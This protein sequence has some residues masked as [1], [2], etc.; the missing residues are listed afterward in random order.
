[1]NQENQN[2]A[3]NIPQPAQQPRSELPPLEPKQP[4]TQ[5]KAPQL[6]KEEIEKKKLAFQK[7]IKI[8]GFAVIGFTAII[9]IFSMAKIIY[10]QNKETYS[11]SQ[12]QES[13][14]SSG[15]SVPSNNQH[16]LPDDSWEIYSSEK[17][18]L[19]FEYPKGDLLKISDVSENEIA[20]QVLSKDIVPQENPT[21]DNLVKGYIFQV[22]PLKLEARDLE[23]AVS[24]KRDFYQ[25]QCAE[26]SSVTDIIGVE[27]SGIE[28]RGFMIYNCNSDYDISYVAANGYIYEVIQIFKGDVGF[29]QVYKAKANQI[30]SL[31]KIEQET[32]AESPFVEF[33]SKYG[34]SFSYPRGLDSQYSN[35]PF[36][37]K[38][39][40]ERVITIAEN[41][42]TN[43]VGFYYDRSPK[44]DFDTY[45]N[46]QIQILIDD[47]V[48]VKGAQPE[49]SKVEFTIDGQKA[50][51]LEG[52]SWRDNDLIYV[53]TPDDKGVVILST[54]NISDEILSNIIES[55]KFEK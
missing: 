12:V 28:G 29:K 38:D 30:A 9:A 25:S 18:G 24:V 7:K 2:P 5:E 23:S 54:T 40:A 31:V 50:V 14:Q 55:I 37:P 21:G 20:I 52:Y 49:G 8:I 51:K 22:K 10:N 19:S 16:P 4:E 43:A 36:P 11:T 34:F 33:E 45:L 3:Q 48:V 42:D 46:E 13:T 1:M 17:Y 6:N 53:K 35:A 41:D 26:T 44:V 39:T 27:V 47:Y 32:I 15:P